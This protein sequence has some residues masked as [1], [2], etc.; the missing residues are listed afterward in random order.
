MASKYDLYW[1][2]RLEEIRT[3]VQLAASGV[4]ATVDVQELR[5]LGARQSW[6]GSV[7]VRGR[8]AAGASTAHAVSLGRIVAASGVCAS[9][10]EHTFRFAVSQAGILAIIVVD[11][12]VR[13]RSDVPV[14]LRLAPRSPIAAGVHGGAAGG[15]EDGGHLDAATGCARIHAALAALPSWLQPAS[16]P[17]ANGLYFFYEEG[18]LS[19]HAPHG[20]VVR[21]GNHPNAPGGLANRLRN[22]FSSGK[23]GSV[24]RRYLGGALLRRQ[25]AHHPCLEPAPGQGHWER[26]NARP[27]TLCTAV[28]SDVSRLLTTAFTFRCVRVDDR[29][30]RNELEKRL[31]ATLAACPACRSSPGWLG[32]YACREEVRSSGL[33]NVHHLDGPLVTEHQLQRFEHLADPVRATHQARV[34]APISG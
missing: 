1:A 2:G 12:A 30:E 25:D 15:I 7:E 6:Y 3:A 23:N 22:H 29:T 8:A 4:S 18:E 9:W 13:A 16:V 19:A 20:R 26:Q 24:F 27:C 31:I 21:V 10:P 28:E 14:D 5:R 34:S 11:G 32:G 17:F 33:W